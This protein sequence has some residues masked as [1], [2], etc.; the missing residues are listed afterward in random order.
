[1][2]KPAIDTKELHTIKFF[3]ALDIYHD[4]ESIHLFKSTYF[5]PFTGM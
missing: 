1:M 4:E 2:A 5:Y 3:T